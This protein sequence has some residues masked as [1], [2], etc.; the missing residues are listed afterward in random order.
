MYALDLET[1]SIR[2]EMQEGFKKADYEIRFYPKFGWCFYISNYIVSEEVHLEVMQ[3]IT[4]NDYDNLEVFLT[5]KNLR[6]RST[7]NT[8]SHW[9]SNIIISTGETA[10]YIW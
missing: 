3:D 2:Q 8:L 5:D 7:V 10:K 4:Y 6:T 1:V 9:G